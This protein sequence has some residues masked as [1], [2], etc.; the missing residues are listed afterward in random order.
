MHHIKRLPITNLL[1][2]SFEISVNDMVSFPLGALVEGPGIVQGFVVTETPRQ[3]SPEIKPMETTILVKVRVS[4]VDYLFFPGSLGEAPKKK[5]TAPK[6][7]P[8][9]PRK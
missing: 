9:L 4:G 7:K 8:R 1:G 6:K 5:T 2:Q 3:L